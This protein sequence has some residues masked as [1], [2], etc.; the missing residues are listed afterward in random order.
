MLRLA[1]IA[2]LG[3]AGLGFVASASAEDTPEQRQVNITG[4]YQ[5]N[6]GDV[7]LSQDGSRVYGTYVCCG[8]GTIEGKIGPGGTIHYVW[9]QPNSWGL[10]V[11]TIE[12]GRLAGTWGSGQHESSGGRWDLTIAKPKQQLAK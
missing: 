11:W 10:G 12:R 2:A 5:S 3:F 6:Y 1:V 7:K 4:T 9:R 8:G